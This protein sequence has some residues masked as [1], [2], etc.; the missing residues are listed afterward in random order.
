[1]GDSDFYPSL[2]TFKV[3][4]LG[5]AHTHPLIAVNKLHNKTE[6]A[7]PAIKIKDHT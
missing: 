6:I 4:V 3:E 1:M 2:F 5:G 7:V